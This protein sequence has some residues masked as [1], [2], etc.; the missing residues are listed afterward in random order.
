MGE[1]N[2]GMIWYLRWI[3]GTTLIL[4]SWGA[5]HAG[6]RSFS[7]SD[8]ERIRAEGP[9]AIIVESGRGTTARAIGAPDAIDQIDIQVQGRM[10]IIRPNRSRWTGWSNKASPAAT[11]RITVPSLKA[12]SMSG[13][14]S[15]TIAKLRTAQAKLWFDGSGSMSVDAVEADR[16]DVTVQG[17]SQMK[18]AGKA[19]QAFVQG[20]G[21]TS[22][23]A[24]ALKTRDLQLTWQSSGNVTIS[25]DR[26]AKVTTAGSGNVTVVGK[27]AC[28]VNAV[29]SGTVSCGK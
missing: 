22:I 4:G 10:L 18:L 8:F 3:A 9:F 24:A 21:P 19:A 23:D 5:A 29:G 11:I 16:L 7:V 6:E 13:S 14:G 15:M 20:V 26:T 25:A 17:S 28:T 12:A 2:P 1:R 27:P